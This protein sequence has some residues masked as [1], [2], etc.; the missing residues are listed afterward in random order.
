MCAGALMKTLNGHVLRFN[1]TTKELS[2]IT[3][4]EGENDVMKIT[5]HTTDGKI[6]TT[7]NNY[8]CEQMD[9]MVKYMPDLFRIHLGHN[10]Y[11]NEKDKITILVAHCS[12]STLS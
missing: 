3:Q 12:Y 8:T 5:L 9:E 10:L 1:S 2:R 7:D 6:Y 4:W 11:F